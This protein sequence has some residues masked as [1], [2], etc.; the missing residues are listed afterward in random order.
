M[1]PILL[2]CYNTTSAQLNLAKLCVESIFLQTIP[3]HL[4]LVDN[5]SHPEIGTKEWLGSLTAPAP[6]RLELRCHKENLPPTSIVNRECRAI[7]ALGAKHVLGV[8]SDTILPPYC[9][10]Q[11]LACSSRG[12]VTAFMDSPEPPRVPESLPDYPSPL[13]AVNVIHSDIHTSV[14]LT[15][16]W[17]VD[18][19]VE[20]DGYFL[21]EGMF[22]YASD[23]DL[24]LRMAACGFRGAQTDLRVWHYS[25]ACWRLAKPEVGGAIHVQA[26]KDRD[27]FAT[28]W[29][30]AIGTPG[31]IAALARLNS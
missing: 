6:H 11:L 3:V 29:G 30:F 15:R 25:S 13:P 24:K 27:H 23:V 21:D 22:M 12:F 4:L 8:P 17:A 2:L 5:G 26:D 1:N 16:K 28:K 9:Y 14:M 20:K 31:H 18:A 10:E 7:F 19:L